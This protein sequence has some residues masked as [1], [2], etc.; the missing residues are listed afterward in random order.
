[1]ERLQRGYRHDIGYSL[2]LLRR[3]IRNQ[4][5]PY[6]TSRAI[7]FS[8]WTTSQ[9][10]CG[11]CFSK[12]SRPSL[13]ISSGQKSIFWNVPGTDLICNLRLRGGCFLSQHP[14]ITSPP[15]AEPKHQFDGTVSVVPHRAA[16]SSAQT[17]CS[18][19]RFFYFDCRFPCHSTDVAVPQVA[20]IRLPSDFEIKST[21]RETT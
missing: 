8:K 3:V 15:I 12:D 18:W 10:G 16:N 7:T 17:D 5:M 13:P 1:M 6:S 2:W 11:H 4:H 20:R 19:D 14:C 9:W 21:E